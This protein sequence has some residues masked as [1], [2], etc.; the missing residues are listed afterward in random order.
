MLALEV[1]A[2]LTSGSASNPF[3]KSRE[4]ANQ[5]ECPAGNN[6][7]IVHIAKHWN[8]RIHSL[9]MPGLCKPNPNTWIQDCQTL[10]G[11]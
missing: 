5:A 7:K 8:C 10:L 4:S 9:Q 11:N 2:Q 1:I 6:T 3:T